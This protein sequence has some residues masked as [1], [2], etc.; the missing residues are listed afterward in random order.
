M[1]VNMLVFSG[2]YLI[3]GRPA[4]LLAAPLCWCHPAKPGLERKSLAGLPSNE[5]LNFLG[6]LG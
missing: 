3:D 5:C 6:S 2:Y 1:N 4:L